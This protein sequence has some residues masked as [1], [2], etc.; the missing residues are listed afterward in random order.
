[1]AL[2]IDIEKCTGCSLCVKACPFAALT[3]VD[4]DPAEIEKA[5]AEGRKLSKKLV[6]VEE[7][8][9]TL[10]GACVDTCK[11]DVVDRLR[12]HRAEPPR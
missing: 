3:I 10:C 7:T 2:I 8:K 6:V 5:K 1:M 12:T 9:C 11:F 4:R